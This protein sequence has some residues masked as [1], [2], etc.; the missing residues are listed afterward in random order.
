MSY[1]P[2]SMYAPA[3]QYERLEKIYAEHSRLRFF[4]IW[5]CAADIITYS[6]LRELLGCSIMGARE[7]VTEYIESN[8]KPDSEKPAMRDMWLVLKG[9][10]NFLD[11]MDGIDNSHDGYDEYVEIAHSRSIVSMAYSVCVM[12]DFHDAVQRAAIS[13]AKGEA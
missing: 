7:M 9:C 8:G 10:K 2:D 6:R 12:G 13:K 4:A 5:C 1:D 3:L 11:S